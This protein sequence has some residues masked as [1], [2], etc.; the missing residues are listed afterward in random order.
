MG[1]PHAYEK[2]SDPNTIDKQMLHSRIENNSSRFPW[3]LEVWDGI[4]LFAIRCWT[5]C[6]DRSD[7]LSE[8]TCLM[9]LRNAPH[10]KM[11]VL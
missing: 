9:A 5:V 2:K 3:I 7:C 6:Q 1:L 10:F 8:I 4:D 11:E